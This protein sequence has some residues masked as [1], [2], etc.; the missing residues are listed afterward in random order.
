MGGK[1]EAPFGGTI[2]HK[3]HGH[4]AGIQPY[5]TVALHPNGPITEPRAVAQSRIF[6]QA[7]FRHRPKEGGFP[8]CGQKVVGHANAGEL[9]PFQTKARVVLQ[10]VGPIGHRFLFGATH[11]YPNVQIHMRNFFKSDMYRNGLLGFLL[12]QR[13]RL[14]LPCMHLRSRAGVIQQLGAKQRAGLSLLI[15]HFFFP[16]VQR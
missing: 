1:I 14:R 10:P 2:G 8:A 13:N 6:H 7:A 11:R 4:R 16:V 5:I 12:A 9:Q 15:Q 3:L